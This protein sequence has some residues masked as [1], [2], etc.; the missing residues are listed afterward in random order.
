MGSCLIDA[1]TILIPDD[2]CPMFGVPRTEVTN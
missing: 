2:S 1:D